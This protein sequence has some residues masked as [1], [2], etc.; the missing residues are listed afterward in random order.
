MKI[1]MFTNTYLPHVGGVARSVSF[2]T[3]DLRAGGH[4]VMVIAPEFPD[5]EAF[6]R[7]DPDLHRVPAIQKFNGSDFSVR[8]PTP[9]V[10]DEA[11]DD[12]GPD[13]IHSHHPYLLG[14]AALRAA[15]RRRLPL[16]F[17]HHTRY[18]AYTH[19]IADNP[20]TMKR[21]AA[22]L[23]TRYA[24]LCDA[25][26]APSESIRDLI[27]ERGVTTQ[28]A[29]IPTGV[30]CDF[31]KTGDGAAFRADQGIPGD[32]IVIGH[33]GRLAP[34]KNLEYLATAVAHALTQR[35]EARFLVVGEGSSQ[36]AISEIFEANGRGD[37]LILAGKLTGEALADAYHAMDLFAF[38]SQSETQG[39]VLTEAMAAGVPVVALDAP[40]VREV[41]EEG[42]NGRMLDSE[43]SPETFGDAL[44]DAMGQSKRRAG[45]SRAARRTA[46]GFSRS[47][48]LEKLL[49]VYAATIEPRVDRETSK[50][51][52]LEPWEKF[53]LACRA[54]WELAAGKA[55]S[56]VKS[57]STDTQIAGLDNEAAV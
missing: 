25:V 17:T 9:F 7:D 36:A 51:K 37:R 47:R 24:E 41:V 33:L 49:R 18:E 35:R 34:E 14:D 21:Y 40:G 27:L 29:V 6:D 20:K 12:F 44:L 10:L 16:I 4:R 32:A 43:V 42:A 11:V 13:L 55:D 26:I 39:M 1:C 23:S 54:E 19:Y 38:A 3:Q 5:C 2:F 46:E 56:I 50:T 53:L 28:T 30:D 22:L 52:D 15:R 57:M 31:F 45:W 8:I 48:G